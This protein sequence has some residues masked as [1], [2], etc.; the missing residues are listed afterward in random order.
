MG[1]T[2]N[3]VEGNY[4]LYDLVTEHNHILQLPETCHLMPSQRKISHVQAF[5]IDM[6]DDSGIRPK[7]AYELASREAGG[8]SNLGYTR[9]DHKN[10]LRTKRQR[11][12]MYGEAGSMLKY[13]QDK[14]VENPSFHYAIQLDCNEQITNIFWADAKMI[15]DYAHFGDVVTFDTTFGTNRDHRPLGVFVGFNHF[16]E[17]VIFGGALLYD[18]TF[19][20]FKWL[21]ETFLAAHNQK[22]PKTIYT[23]QDMAMKKAIAAVFP[24]TWHGLCT[25][26]IMQNAVKH[27][28]HTKSD[29]PNILGEFSACMFE[30]EDE[31]TFE[32]AFS[33]LRSKVHND[34]WLASIYK[35]KEKWAECYMKNALTLGMRS[36]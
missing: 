10:Y 36:T 7:A 29:G 3:R 1:I 12:L 25:F 5:E 32:K 16:R 9:L 2:L 22:H 8:S 23:D 31:I 18:E 24:G 35:H 14:C 17:T 13:F 11:N 34:S 20:S 6:A 28:P 33:A 21:F 15:I 19:E 30:Y 4:E 26:H 27:L